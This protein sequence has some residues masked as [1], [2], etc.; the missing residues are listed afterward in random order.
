MEKRIIKS[1]LCLMFTVP[2]MALAHTNIK[3]QSSKDEIDLAP[4]L[5]EELISSADPIDILSKQQLIHYWN[6]GNNIQAIMPF[7]NSSLYRRILVVDF[8]DI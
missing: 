3:S 4:E 2:F 1:I 7:R 6:L 5:V 8:F